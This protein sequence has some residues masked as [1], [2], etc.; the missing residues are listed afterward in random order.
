VLGPDHPDTLT[1]RNNIAF[2]RAETGQIQSAIAAFEALLADRT[3]V[4]GPD[5]PDTLRTR[6]NIATNR[7]RAV[8]ERAG[9]HRFGAPP[10]YTRAE[11]PRLSE[12]ATT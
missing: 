3:R 4:L 10:D 9:H 7:A 12:R 1:T 6:H 8:P 5:H 2:F 11:T